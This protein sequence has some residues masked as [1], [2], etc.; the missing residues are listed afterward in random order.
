MS[1]RLTIAAKEI[2]DHLRD[3]RS[4]VS[5]AMYSLM[6]PA[7]I[8]LVAQSAAARRGGAG[9]LLSMMSV[10]TLVSAF[11]GG[12]FL[13]LDSTAGERE[14]GSLV[15]LLLNPVSRRDLVIGKWLAASAFA[16]AGLALNLAGFTLVFEWRGAAPPD[17]SSRVFL[18][19]IVCG[20]VPLALLGAALNLLAAVACRTVKEAYTRLSI[21]TFVPMIV[22]M[23]LV[24]FP[25]W[26]VR[27][28]YTLPVVGQQALIGAGLRGE[29]VSAVQ[30]S[31]L[32][33]VTLAA[34]ALAILAASRALNR[35][36]ILAA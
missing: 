23:S 18:L 15:P 7:V 31:I 17:G 1:A 20:L 13:A 27:W 34:A 10:F 3:R 30:S 19:W 36:D 5:A 33:I 2:R 8:L 35:D 21:V 25:G 32:G 28:W 9:L 11:T 26:I 6:G 12:M 22:G 14:R 29:A 4:L 16:L 24:F